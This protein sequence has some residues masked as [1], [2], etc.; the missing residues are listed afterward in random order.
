MSGPGAFPGRGREDLN[1]A[2]VLPAGRGGGERGRGRRLETNV[3]AKPRLYQHLYMCRNTQ[4]VVQ[5]F[6]HVE[7]NRNPILMS[8]L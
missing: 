7:W 2:G 6:D 3:F 5:V 4:L 1:V 8:L